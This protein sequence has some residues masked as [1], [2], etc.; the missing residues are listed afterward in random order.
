[1]DTL[2]LNRLQ[3]RDLARLT[4]VLASSLEDLYAVAMTLPDV[5]GDTT[6]P[7]FHLLQAWTAATAATAG[8][9]RGILMDTDAHEAQRRGFAA[10]HRR[11]FGE[12]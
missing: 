2:T 6:T 12:G 3:T 5:P 11:R 10:A 8:I 4:E 7:R 1:V 9:Q